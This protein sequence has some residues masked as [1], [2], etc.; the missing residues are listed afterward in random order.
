MIQC[1]EGQEET[2]AGCPHVDECYREELILDAWG[3]TL[4]ENTLDEEES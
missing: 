4:G 2:C 1:P 3:L